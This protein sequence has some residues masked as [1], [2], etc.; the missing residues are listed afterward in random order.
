[1]NLK[2]KI[3]T[4]ATIALAGATFAMGGG[5][6][7]GAAAIDSVPSAPHGVVAQLTPTGDGNFVIDVSWTA[8]DSSNGYP[9]AYSVST[10]V[11]GFACTTAAATSCRLDGTMP[12][13]YLVGIF[14]RAENLS[15]ISD[16]DYAQEVFANSVVPTAPTAV[17]SLPGDKNIN[18]GWT[19]SGDVSGA[20]VKAYTATAFDAIGNPAG[21]CTDVLADSNSN[22]CTIGNLQNGSSYTVSVVATNVVGSSEASAVTDPVTPAGAPD[23]P[24][25]I[26]FSF[27]PDG[28]GEFYTT[29]SW[30]PPASDGGGTVTSYSVNSTTSGSAYVDGSTTSVQ[31]PYANPSGYLDAVWVFATNAYGSSPRDWASPQLLTQVPSVPGSPTHVSLTPG[32]SSIKVHWVA[33]SADGSG[34]TDTYV[35]G[36]SPVTSYEATAAD[37]QG[38]VVG[39]CTNAVG[40]DPEGTC[41]ISGL[42][43]SVAYMVTVAAA[44][45]TGWS[46]A[47]APVSAPYLEPSS[48]FA[49]YPTARIVMA[50]TTATAVISG[51]PAATVVN[52]TLA[53]VVTKC[54]TNSAGQCLASVTAK[55]G[56]KN[57]TANFGTG[58]SK[59]TATSAAKV[60]SVLVSVPKTGT[61]GKAFKVI[62]TAAAPGS[63][64]TARIDIGVHRQ[65]KSAI[66]SGTGAATLLFTLSSVKG[67]ATVTV[68]DAGIVIG[69]SSITI[70]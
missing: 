33:P 39:R 11:G 15:G 20:P 8:S 58:K 4:L 34:G 66:A 37:L 29:V 3:A 63:T 36:P 64:V 49:V 31:L 28:H 19:P 18:V 6:V 16:I 56:V 23:T 44:N 9:I 43:Q 26:R 69:S 68:D 22:S 51:A 41:T 60:A 61:H 10:T 62:V 57:V 5:G 21:S 40:V 50:G 52:V 67:A 30:S 48:K 35:T 1:M 32:A 7:A 14:V 13:N 42:N 46:V 54:T 12:P 53:G 24:S 55:V 17:T 59:R 70:K 47:S 2:H 45:F 38:N 25:N 27:N 65:I